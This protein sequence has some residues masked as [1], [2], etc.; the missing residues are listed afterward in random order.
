MAGS[1]QS[2]GRKK[3][4]AASKPKRSGEPQ[5]EK[6]ISV[7]RGAGKTTVLDG[8]DPL[9]D[10]EMP[11]RWKRSEL[12]P[13][14]SK[15][16]PVVFERTRAAAERAL[17]NFRKFYAMVTLWKNRGSDMEIV[18]QGVRADDVNLMMGLPSDHKFYLISPDDI[19]NL[20]ET[21]FSCV[22]DLRLGLRIR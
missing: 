19:D 13:A 1:R 12:K 11:R 8:T 16:D 9:N 21:L 18:V 4:V 3:K 7:G 17:D 5:R 20:T 15:V 14:T 22:E 2:K 6:R 10:G